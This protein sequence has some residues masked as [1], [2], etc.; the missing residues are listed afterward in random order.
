M[1]NLLLMKAELKEEEDEE[2]EELADQLRIVEEK[3]QVSDIM[4]NH[5]YICPF[6]RSFVR[7]F[8]PSYLSSF[9]HSYIH[10]FINQ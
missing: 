1:A 8:I 6:I 2:K 9:I 7:T 5:S 10:L 3:F 4:S